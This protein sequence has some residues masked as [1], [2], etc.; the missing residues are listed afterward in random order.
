MRGQ[1]HPYALFGNAAY[2]PRAW[3]LTHYIGSKD[4]FNR[5]QEYWNFI[6]SSSGMCVERVFGIL[7]LQWRILLKRMDCELQNVSIHVAACL[8]LHNF[9]IMHNDNFNASWIHEGQSE[10]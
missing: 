5:R 6:Q 3:M 2:Q 8:I 4:G 9:T 10:L 1:L 7:K